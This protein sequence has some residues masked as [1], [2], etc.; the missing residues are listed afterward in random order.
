M[1]WRLKTRQGGPGEH[2]KWVSLLCH[3][4]QPAGGFQLCQGTRRLGRSAESVQDLECT[5]KGQRDKREPLLRFLF[6]AV[7]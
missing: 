4:D 3:L 1:S 6:S 2:L 5:S 7:R